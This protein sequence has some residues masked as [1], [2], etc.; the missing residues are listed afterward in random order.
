MRYLIL[1]LAIALV[2]CQNEKQST[3]GISGELKNANGETIVLNQ[4]KNNATVILDSARIDASGAFS[5][6]GATG[7]FDFYTLVLNNQQVVLLTDSTENLKVTGDA[8]DLLKTYD[9]SG[10]E[11]SKVLRDYYAGAA[12]YRSEM[13]SI[14]QSFQSV[15]RSNDNERK[16]ALIDAFEKVRED[17][18]A[19]QVEFLNANYTSPACIS[20]LGE[21]KP[22]EHLDIFKKVQGGIADT[23]SDHLYFSMLSNQIAEAEKRQAAA[24]KL[25]AGKMAPEIELPNPEGEVIPLSS[26]RGK[27][28]LID[29]WAS[30]CKPC[31]RE[32]PNV[33]KMYNAH[34]D[35]GFEIYGVS[36]DRNKEKWVQAIAQDGLTWPQVSDLKFWNSAAA[37][38]YN[39]SSIP[40]TVLI[41]REGKI[42]ATGL[43][44]NALEEKVKESLTM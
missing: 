19:Y 24:E 2:A 10:S 15:A 9:V 13:D 16:Q 40:H 36:L 39:V 35:E 20:I 22:E 28:V 5:F 33:V 18:S 12:A 43:R 31:R 21:M 32:N 8:E 17:Y 4:I 1:I 3:P 44:G 25:Q 11:H 29:F 38:L 27:V 30:W 6:Q 26:L 41:D 37:K 34:K 7:P 14:Q 23:F 42:I